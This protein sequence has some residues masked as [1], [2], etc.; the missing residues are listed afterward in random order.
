MKALHFLR[1]VCLAVVASAP[2]V[3]VQFGADPFLDLIRYGTG[4]PHDRYSVELKWGR[5]GGTEAAQAWLAAADAAV[6]SAPLTTLPV[7][8]AIEVGEDVD[9]VAYAL[10]LKRGQRLVIDIS[11][12]ESWGAASAGSATPFVDLFERSESGVRRVAHAAQGS[13]TLTFDTD[14]DGTYVIRWQSPLAADAAA[15]PVAMKTEPTLLLPVKQANRR[16]IGSVYGDPRDG[17]RRDHHGVDIFA[18]RGTPVVAAA[19]GIVTRVGTNGLG[20]KVVWISRPFH[21]ESH[22][23][24]H[25]DEQLVT[26]GTRVE[27]G[28]VIGLVGNTGN[29]RSTPPHLHFGIY[30][31]SG[32]VDPLPYLAS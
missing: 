9:A 22:Y 12:L 29:A 19:G 23:Y 14:R 3:W 1:V 6:A 11:Q 15:I 2:I 4:S 10:P 7:T 13:V 16:S 25:L 26:V 21:G 32:A 8:R 27:E 28:D 17:G 31:A 5:L 20:G 18:K 24:A 30:T